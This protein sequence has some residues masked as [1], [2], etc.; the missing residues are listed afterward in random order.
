VIWI[1][2]LRLAK[3]HNGAVLLSRDEVH[4]HNRGDDEANEVGLVR[5][6][7][8]DQALE[9]L[10]SQS[11]VATRI[12]VILESVWE[13]LRTQGFPITEF[14]ATLAVLSSRFVQG[15]LGLAEAEARIRI[16][17]D[18]HGVVEFSLRAGF[19][20][21]LVSIV[22]ISD[23]SISNGSTVLQPFTIKH[24]A[25]SQN[26]QREDE[27]QDYESRLSALRQVLGGSNEPSDG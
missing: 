16:K 11:P 24:P 17:T 8:V 18:I 22:T 27:K 26:P 10:G 15:D 2:S 12:R 13:E 19:C 4:T 5:F 7:N 20:R 6:N 23:V 9:F 1:L 14:P 21:G 3:E 25:H